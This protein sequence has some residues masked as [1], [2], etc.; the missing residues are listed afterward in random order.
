M[1]WVSFLSWHRFLENVFVSVKRPT[2]ATVTEDVTGAASSEVRVWKLQLCV[3]HT[4]CVRARSHL[5]SAS[6]DTLSVQSG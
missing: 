3:C 5:S 2:V 1:F 4:K 6:L